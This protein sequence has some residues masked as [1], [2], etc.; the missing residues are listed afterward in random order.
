MPKAKGTFLIT[1]CRYKTQTH[2][3][4]HD[5]RKIITLNLSLAPCETPL[6]TSQLFAKFN[7]KCSLFLFD[8][9]QGRLLACY[10]KTEVQIP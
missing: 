6:A 5:F 1:I 8:M 10:F 9:H 7:L 4:G 3:F 2:V